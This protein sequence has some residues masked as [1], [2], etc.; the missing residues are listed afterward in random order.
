MMSSK[1]SETISKHLRFG[2]GFV[3]FEIKPNIYDE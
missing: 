1:Y 3:I 2:N